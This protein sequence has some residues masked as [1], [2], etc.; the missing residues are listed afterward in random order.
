MWSTGYYW[1]NVKHWLLLKE[2]EALA[3]IERMCS[4][5]YYWK[6]VKHWLLLKKPSKK[7]EL[8]IF[9]VVSHVYS[10]LWIWQYT[11]KLSVEALIRKT[12]IGQYILL[13]R[14]DTILHIL[15]K[16]MHCLKV[17][18]AN[19]CRTASRCIIPNSTSEK[20]TL[21]IL[22]LVI[23]CSIYTYGSLI[24]KNIPQP[25]DTM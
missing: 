16:T 17:C 11:N 2:C 20:G 1:K 15:L 6:N 5:G 14:R 8:Y 12:N 4:T 21:K 13:L 3:T 24:K 10:T 23:V 7:R 19:C 22:A 25:S 18:Y 9:L